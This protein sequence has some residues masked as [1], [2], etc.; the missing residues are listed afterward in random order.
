MAQPKSVLC[1]IRACKQSE[2]TYQKKKPRTKSHPIT[3]RSHAIGRQV[4]CLLHVLCAAPARSAYSRLAQVLAR[5]K[6]LAA[7]KRP[8]LK[9]A[10]SGNKC[11]LFSL[12]KIHHT[13]ASRGP[14]RLARALSVTGAISC[15][16]NA[17]R[18]QQPPANEAMCSVHSTR[19]RSTCWSARRRLISWSKTG[20]VSTS[21]AGAI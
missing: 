8:V 7:A 10:V 15:G 14:G 21:P 13:L 12:H 2:L 3:K 20:I 9:P 19:S 16:I 5:K 18:K 17:N 4:M 1:P 11:W 6:D